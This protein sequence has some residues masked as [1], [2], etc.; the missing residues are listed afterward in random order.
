MRV[1][2]QGERRRL[3]EHFKGYF[4]GAIG[5]SHNWSSSESWAETDLQESM[6]AAAENPPLFLE[7]FWLACESANQEF[8]V[9]T[10]DVEH[11]NDIC[12]E[13]D[14]AFVVRPPGIEAALA[15]GPP[16]PTEPTPPTLSESAAAAWQSCRQRSEQL[17]SD[18]RPR[19]AVQEMLWILESLSTAFRGLPT[20]VGEVKGK[21]FN[22]IV[23]E[24]RSAHRGTTLDRVGEWCESLHGYLSSPTGGGVR[25]GLDI[26]SGTPITA[27]E[28][29]LMCNLLASFI[30]FLLSEH[31][32]LAS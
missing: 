28:G 2:G 3:I 19:E 23:A 15:I 8:G 12:R 17:L 6:L 24:L 5:A 26:M 1:A 27:A 13:F 4:A 25:H 14:V 10:P 11:V 7:A 16:V 9:S 18:G 31:E 30:G 20:P 29:R 22:R 21:Y 32:R